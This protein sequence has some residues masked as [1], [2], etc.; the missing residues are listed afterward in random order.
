MPDLSPRYFGAPVELAPDSDRAPG[1]VVSTPFTTAQMTERP[2][3][4][5]PLSL[6][7]SSPD[8]QTLFSQTNDRFSPETDQ[9]KIV[10]RVQTALGALPVSEAAVI[11][12][13]NRN[14]NSEIVTFQLTDKSGKT[15]EFSVSAP[16]KSDSQ[17]PSE[18]LPF[19]DY[20]ITIRHPQYYTA[21]I[22]NVQVFGDVL[23]IL[24]AELTPLPELVNETTT[25]TTITIPRQNL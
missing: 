10:V 20:D 25:T 22:Q 1:G 23:T 7:P 17:S 9:G 18:T 19:S 13:A 2:S 3:S 14:G 4:A 5:E 8:R 11:V 24:V 15:P 6:E 12:S 21:I 16:P